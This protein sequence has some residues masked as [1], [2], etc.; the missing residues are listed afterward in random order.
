MPMSELFV[1]ATFREAKK[2]LEFFNAKPVSDHLYQSDIGNI[3]ICGV[4]LFEPL[5]RLHQ[6]ECSSITNLGCAGGLCNTLKLFDLVEVSKVSLFLPDD[7]HHEEIKT[8]LEYTP[9]LPIQ[10]KGKYLATSTYPIKTSQL[11]QRAKKYDLVDMEGYS[12]A[13]F[14]NKHDIPCK[15]LKVISDFS[16]EGSVIKE[17]LE[18]V[19]LVL[20]EFLK[21][22]LSKKNSLR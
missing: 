7:L 13:Y 16:D 20:C 8:T 5:F 22:N 14:A 1:F 18:Q 17:R 6:I 4:G 12:I 11:K 19:S 21:K 2:T 3:L 15:M 9:P 10:E